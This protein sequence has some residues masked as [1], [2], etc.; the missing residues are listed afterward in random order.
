MPDLRH[1]IAQDQ[2][3]YSVIIN[4][5]VPDDSG[6]YECVAINNVGE[7]RC[8]AEAIVESTAPKDKGPKKPETVDSA[9][10]IVEQLKSVSVSE[11]ET[12]VLR[13]RIQGRPGS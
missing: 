11:G 3:T 2:T 4:N 7:A 13:A 6:R 9:P 12:V 8:E 1:K 10:V 5:T